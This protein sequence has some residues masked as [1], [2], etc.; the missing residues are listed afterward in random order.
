MFGRLYRPLSTRETIVD[1]Q[2]PLT[3]SHVPPP[4]IK[5][6]PSV[7]SP[8]AGP[9]FVQSPAPNAAAPSFPPSVTAMQDVSEVMAVPIEPKPK[10]DL[11]RLC[12]TI[13]DLLR[14]LCA[15]MRY[16]TPSHAWRKMPEIRD[17]IEQLHGE[18]KE[19]TK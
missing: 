5:P 11:L 13:V 2:K 16:A 6:P 1:E 4:P 12:S 3:V 10:V 9:Q 18:L 15:E 19:L 14:D 8:F 17:K 7:P